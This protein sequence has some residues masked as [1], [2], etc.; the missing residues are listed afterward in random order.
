MSNNALDRLINK[1]KPKVPPRNDVVSESVSND[2]KTQG[3]QELNTSLPPSDTKA[4]PEEMPT[5][6]ESETSLSQDQKPKLSPD[7]FETVRNTI[8]IESEVDE[9]LRQLCHEERITKETWLEAA[10]LYLCEKPEELAQV[11]QLAQERLSQR[12]AIADYKRAKTMQE[13]FL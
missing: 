10:Y 13:R 7:T 5:S 4:T 11:I 9:S 1:Q 8:R 12:K 3:Q 6:H 2:I